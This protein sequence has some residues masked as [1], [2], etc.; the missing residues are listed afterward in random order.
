MSIGS[1][2][3]FIR[4]ATCVKSIRIEWDID[5]EPVAFCTRWFADRAYDWE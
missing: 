3:L 2:L 5:Q 4:G 1:P